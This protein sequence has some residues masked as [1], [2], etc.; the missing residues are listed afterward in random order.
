MEA[1]DKTICVFP[2]INLSKSLIMDDFEIHPYDNYDF[3]QE[4]NDEEKKN[5]DLFVDSFRKTFFQK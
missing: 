1:V 4:L 2:Y 5:L 3:T